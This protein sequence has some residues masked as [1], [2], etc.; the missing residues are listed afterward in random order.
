MEIAIR[1]AL[2]KVAEMALDKEQRYQPTSTRARLPLCQP[3]NTRITCTQSGLPLVMQ[4]IYRSSEVSMQKP[5]RL[6]VQLRMCGSKQRLKRH[7]R[8]DLVGKECG[9]ESMTCNGQCSKACLVWLA[10][11]YTSTRRT[12]KGPGSQRPI[13][14]IISLKE[15]GSYDEANSSR[16]GMPCTL[17]DYT[18]V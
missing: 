14:H 9:S 6:F 15:K 3:S 1:S 7:R 5:G 10:N 18:Q 16:D 2:T 13:S 8:N 17:K 11:P 4:E 12:S